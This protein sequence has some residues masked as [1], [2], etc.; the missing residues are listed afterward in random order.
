M[1]IAAFLVKE[2]PTVK[3]YRKRLPFSSTG[4]HSKSLG[5]DSHSRPLHMFLHVPAISNQTSREHL[6]LIINYP[7]PK[8]GWAKYSVVCGL[9]GFKQPVGL[10]VLTLK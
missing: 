2:R 5:L 7:F 10:S 9:A 6:D 1:C 8:Q 4:D 3:T